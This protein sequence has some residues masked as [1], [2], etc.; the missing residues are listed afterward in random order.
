[1]TDSSDFPKSMLTTPSKVSL[2]ML[3]VLEASLDDTQTI[4]NAMNGLCILWAS[5]S[6]VF[7]SIVNSLDSDYA[8]LYP[9]RALT[10]AQLYPHLS[11]YD[12]VNLAATPASMT[13]AFGI[14]KSQILANAV[15]VDD[16][17]AEIH[18]PKTSF[19]NVGPIQV[20]LYHDI[21]IRVNKNTQSISVLYDTSETSPF[22]TLDSNMM[23]QKPTS[24][25]R[26]MQDYLLFGFKVYQ[27][28][29]DTYNKSV[30]SL[31]GYSWEFSFNNN[32]FAALVFSVG[33]DGTRTPLEIGYDQQYYDVNT[34]TA[35][36]ALDNVANTITVTIPQIYLEKNL[37]SSKISVEVYSTYGQMAYNIP[38]A[39]AAD[40]KAS[41]DS[42]GDA[43]A[44][45][46]AKLSEYILHP[47]ESTLVG[48]SSPKTFSQMKD[49]VVNQTFYD[50]IPITPE[51]LAAKAAASGYGLALIVDDITNRTYFASNTLDDSD[52]TLLP[53]LSGSI[54]LSGDSLNNDP[55]S[56]LKF[57]D[58]SILILPTT[59][60]QLGQTGSVCTPLSDSQ[61]SY[62]SS[63]TKEN[64]VSEM[65]STTYLRQPFY[66]SLI[67][68]PVYPIARPYNL[69]AP[70]ANSLV[71]VKENEASDSQMT[72]TSVSIK[73]L[74]DGTGGYQILFAV[75]LTD[76]L[77][78]V[79]T[80]TLQLVLSL[81]TS[82]NAY[83]YAVGT[84]VA[85]TDAN[86]VIFS[87][88]LNT[89]YHI[90]TSDN[91]TLNLTDWNGLDTA[92]QVN[93]SSVA[94]I[95][96]MLPNDNNISNDNTIL[97]NIPTV[98]K[99]QLCV[100]MQ[101]VTLTLGTN[102]EKSIY[103]AVNTTWGNDVYKT[104]DTNVYL[105]VTQ[106]LYQRDASNNIV[107]RPV[108]NAD[109]SLGLD[110]VEIYA[111]GEELKV[112]GDI[113][114]TLS[115]IGVAVQ[116]TIT[117]NDSTGVL[118]GML[119]TCPGIAY[120]ITVKSVAGNVIT[121]SAALGVAVSNGA[122][123]IFSNKT[124]STSTTADQ[125][126]DALDTLA[127]G[128]TGGIYVG[129][130]VYGFD[131]A[132]GAT[133][134]SIVDQTTIKVSVAS[135]TAVKSGT[136]LTF[137]NK[138][139]PGQILHAAG[140]NV[141]DD[142]GAPIIIKDRQNQYRIPAIL[143]DG[144]IYESGGVSDQALVASIPTLLND[145]ASGISTINFG[146]AEQRDV[147]YQP[148]RTIGTANFD[149]GNGVI[150]NIGLSMGLA[151]EFYLPESIYAND[152]IK[153]AI[154]TLTASEFSTI[155]SNDIISVF[156]LAKSLQTKLGEQITG[157]ALSG[158]NGEDDLRVCALSDAGCKPSVRKI[159]Y[160][161]DDGVIDRKPDITYAFLASPDGA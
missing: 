82:T 61:V 19:F 56:I 149:I 126:A 28:T 15:D 150:E 18:I 20:S 74:M 124:M 97:P 144:R 143:F 136:L 36:L 84:V 129:Q 7:S 24:F 132:A 64:L 98:L 58:G 54:L 41:F 63:L 140:D 111:A 48:G 103:S 44:A 116:N 21:I 32:F 147:Y 115:A 90:D 110:Y 109:G 75:S 46:L 68:D 148:N 159:L 89:T 96:L 12:Y 23:E 93:L 52:G 22:E 45:P 139:A 108:Q 79:D 146:F 134:V 29:R 62:L 113:T 43:Y 47:L 35:I 53:V 9:K 104:Y 8:T 151:A 42:S 142:T 27:F 101:S 157:V 37:V 112:D 95:L 60:F 154:Q 114:T 99:D 25:R 59:V 153:S 34:P 17:Y 38:L 65:N 3:D 81:P 73:H 135:T 122:T 83:A 121:L 11:K 105:T 13:M 88:K 120:G 137:L 123:V 14:V 49:G 94:N 55:S 156:D 107:V 100:A 119:V 26:N 128:S 78:S 106:A 77:K 67:P 117:V 16:V 33:A 1:M 4:P 130:S 133:V 160:I 39:D 125:S 138:T 91:I 2:A 131:V 80:S 30:T 92:A 145:Y 86:N 85:T 76:S 40:V 51:E 66:L 10:P 141:L 102:M 127:V 57:T 152:S 71:Y 50:R 5:A 6:G 161:R 70:T 87:V 72:V 69:L 31:E 118:A 155:L 158:L